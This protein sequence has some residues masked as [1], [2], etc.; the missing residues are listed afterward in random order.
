MKKVLRIGIIGL[1][2]RWH[3]RYMPA[4]RRMRGL[5]KISVVCDQRQERA[6]REAK[7][8]ACDAAASPTQLLERE[9]VDAVLL[10]DRQW[11]G[12]W[13]LEQAC[14]VGK[15]VLCCCSLECDD[16][17]AEGLYQQVR[18][19]RLPVIMEMLPRFAPVTA[20]LRSLFETDLGAPRLLLCNVA[21]RHAPCRPRARVPEYSPL[22]A[23]FGGS[24]IPLLD[25]CAGLLGD[26]PQNISARV[27]QAIGFS[28][29]FLEFSGGRGVQLTRRPGEL[30][31]LRLEILAERGSALVD[32]PHRVS[33][34]TRDGLHSSALRGRPPLARLLL[35][36]FRDVVQ[37]RTAP[38]PTF[39][40][41][42]RV[43]R[44]LRVADR[45]RDE[46]RLLTVS[47]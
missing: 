16:A 40:E 35:E 37:G 20:R 12:L 5:F 3:K 45:S 7:G 8:L 41:A 9:D 24:G 11:F 14:S 29:L 18:D 28:S 22:A 21:S 47:G 13:P 43:L 46:V 23:L 38:Q 31:A 42:Y 44:W 39:D 19:S 30:P 1:G 2:R 25:W 15:P 34:A 32:F 17:H 27:L 26:E 10:L 4:L 6:A 36:H 33:W